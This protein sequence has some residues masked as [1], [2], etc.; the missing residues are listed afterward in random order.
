MRRGH[1][2]LPMHRTRVGWIGTGVM[3]QPMAGHLLAAGYP[4]TVFT[5]TAARAQ[6]L[7]AAGARWAPSPAEVAAQSDVV[8]SIVGNPE[9]VKEVHLG[10]E[11]TLRAATPPRLIVDMTTSSP[12]LAARI[13]REACALGSAALDAP[14][15]GGDIGACN[16]TLS[17][18]CGGTQRDFEDARPL[19][20]H[21]GKTVTLQGGPG[22]G[23]HAKCVNQIL[24]AGTMLGLAEGLAYARAAG[25]DAQQVLAAVGGGAA[26]SWSLANLAPRILRGDTAPGFFVEHFIKDL[27][28]ALGEA[29]RLHLDLAMVAMAEQVYTR[30]AGEG[31]ARSG[32]QAVVAAY[33]WQFATPANDSI[34]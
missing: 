11:G 31:H 9:G 10:P 28:I 33:G 12:E 26:G 4:L 22:A 7:V 27:R 25:L 13:A 16:A 8:F 23:Q 17:I 34:S 15:S 29:R 24:I 1:T 5:R 14:V 19:L 18:M 30:L 32:T 6:A 20:A 3:G 21:L 2:L